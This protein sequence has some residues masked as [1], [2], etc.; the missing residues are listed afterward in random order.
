MARV[1]ADP[2]VRTRQLG[3]AQTL[4][5]LASPHSAFFGYPF[6]TE[7]H[8]PPQVLCLD[9]PALNGSLL[10]TPSCPGLLFE[11]GEVSPNKPH[12]THNANPRQCSHG[13]R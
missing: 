11:P 7:P 6:T 8:R 5:A 3:P 13:R 10:L 4:V 2:P 1:F 12:A 9:Q